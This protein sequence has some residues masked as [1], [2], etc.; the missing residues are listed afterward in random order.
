ME[1]VNKDVI[2]GITDPII[3]TI[4]LND[5]FDV[6]NIWISLIETHSKELRTLLYVFL[7]VAI[8]SYQD[9][10]DGGGGGYNL[11][12]DEDEDD[13]ED[14]L[15]YAEN[16]NPFH[17]HQQSSLSS[18]GNS[19]SS[20]SR[21]IN[22]NTHNGKIYLVI[23]KA[24]T[25]MF[26]SFIVKGVADTFNN[27]YNRLSGVEFQCQ[28]ESKKNTFELNYESSLNFYNCYSKGIQLNEFQE[29]LIPTEVFSLKDS[30]SFLKVKSGIDFVFDREGRPYNSFYN[31]ATKNFITIVNRI[32]LKSLSS[33]KVITNSF[34]IYDSIFE[35]HISEL[36]QEFRV[37]KTPLEM[38]TDLFSS[39]QI[40]LIRQNNINP[41]RKFQEIIME[42][43]IMNK[44]A[45]E[46]ASGV[47]K[48]APKNK[49]RKIETGIFEMKI[50]GKRIDN[51]FDLLNHSVRKIKEEFK[52]TPKKLLKKKR[53]LFYNFWTSE[54]TK[55]KICDSLKDLI[56]KVKETF[57]SKFLIIDDETIEKEKEKY[58]DDV[59]LTPGILTLLF[60]MSNLELNLNLGGGFA[61]ALLQIMANIIV[62]NDFRKNFNIW[63]TG[64]SGVGKTYLA[65]MIHDL[66][67]FVLYSKYTTIHKSK[68][69][70]AAILNN[71]DYAFYIYPEAERDLMDPSNEMYQE[72]LELMHSDTW[73]YDVLN[74][75][76]RQQM[77]F[78]HHNRCGFLFCSNYAVKADTQAGA[79][80]TR[81][82]QIELTTEKEKTRY[83]AEKKRQKDFSKKTGEH[84]EKFRNNLALIQLVLTFYFHSRNRDLLQLDYT[85]SCELPFVT[86]SN[87]IIDEFEKKYFSLGS[88][89]SR[90]L[91]DVLTITEMFNLF[92]VV[93][94][95]FF[96]EH[97]KY[98]FIKNTIEGKSEK[99]IFNKLYDVLNDIQIRN[100]PTTQDFVF[101]MC[102][103]N[104]ELTSRYLVQIIDVIK[105]DFIKYTGGQLKFVRKRD[106]CDY[107]RNQENKGQPIFKKVY[108]TNGIYYDLNFI[109]IQTGM[110]GN[111][112]YTY[113]SNSIN[114]KYNMDCSPEI[115][116][117]ICNLLS[118]KTKKIPKKYKFINSKTMEEQDRGNNRGSFS[119]M[120]NRTE[121]K[122]VE[123]DLEPVQN[124]EGFDQKLFEIKVTKR[125]VEYVTVSVNIFLLDKKNLPKLDPFDELM[126]IFNSEVFYEKS[127][128]KE[129][130]FFDNQNIDNIKVE[131]LSG[132]SGQGTVRKEFLEFKNKNFVP[133]NSSFFN[134]TGL[135]DGVGND[136]NNG[137]LKIKD[138]KRGLEYFCGDLNCEHI[139][140]DMNLDELVRKV[141]LRNIFTR[142]NFKNHL[143]DDFYDEFAEDGTRED[144]EENHY[145]FFLEQ[146]YSEISSFKVTE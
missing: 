71:S 91:E 21:I 115:I 94:E 46:L 61:A 29:D 141:Y 38:S 127:N 79:G 75:E 69:F 93:S 74:P 42:P 36:L 128:F 143:S 111:S 31:A 135:G 2:A 27:T 76:N 146:K 73:A 123:I 1:K 116:K 43:I 104:F 126:D 8:I 20:R 34:T 45:K 65:K 3:L 129:F 11:M 90:I 37:I 131:K 6:S 122:E 47:D 53:E 77:R 98:R 7:K 52:E 9:L 15:D 145:E 41:K 96:F 99:F 30:L 100:T 136:N 14:D 87:R 54:F 72:L 49:K 139:K 118:T 19:S 113:V 63:M 109:E 24:G 80:R 51:V 132:P 88:S 59:E 64:K 119:T 17:Q 125:G 70:F 102:L 140:I 101:A 112:F 107:F 5:F 44:R 81:L 58:G 22:E 25:S 120:V 85:E 124:N 66:C 48:D 144:S 39:P 78:E 60:F 10:G 23:A 142:E 55:K 86:L 138:E 134:W 16:L 4:K 137:F 68:K 108:V 50:N 13:D 62:H 117:Y 105:N 83:S 133:I 110:D 106:F 32:N 67:R 114:S 57:E 18:G 92:R 56:T 95:L 89:H 97:S 12:L 35:N 130:M 40:D 26:L 28:M 84:I 82:E 103:M 33:L 121:I